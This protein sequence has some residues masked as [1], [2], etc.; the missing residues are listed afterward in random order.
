M[1]KGGGGKSVK[2]PAPTPVPQEAETNAAKRD[3]LESNLRKKGRSASAV[4][5]PALLL[6]SPKLGMS[7]LKDTLG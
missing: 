4:I 3:V 7:T 1:G 6:T 5:S 2:T